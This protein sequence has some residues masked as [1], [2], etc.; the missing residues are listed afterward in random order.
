MYSHHSHSIDHI[1][2]GVDSL[3]A[4]IEEV[5]RQEFHTYCLTEHT[6]RLTPSLL[7]PEER[8][9]TEQEDLKRLE[10]QFDSYIT[11]AQEIKAVTTGTSIIIGMEVEACDL[12]HINYAIELKEKHSSVLKF[13]VGSV[14]HVNGIPI[15]FSEDLWL[16][17]LQ[18]V[19]NN[20]KKLL[21]EYFNMQYVMLKKLRPKIVGHFDLIRLFIPKTGAYVNTKSG[22]VS[23]SQSLDVDNWI[24]IS[25]ISA[26]VMSFWNDIQDLIIRNLTLI[27]EYEGLVEINSS[28]F[29]KGL[30]EP[31]PHRDVGLLVKKYAKGRFVLSDDAHAVLHVGRDYDRVLDYAEDVLKLKGLHF[32]SENRA[33]ELEINFVSLQ[34]IRTSNFWKLKYTFAGKSKL[35]DGMDSLSS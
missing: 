29:R 20:L 9:N 26:N 27:D 21:Y 2:H 30:L 23:F 3:E 13:C 18:S 17:A 6:P 28:A 31:Y 24:P 35:I 11:H 5:K 34:S 25:A 8:C 1:A 7:Y 12:R 33:G 32:L 4:I 22:E 10:R 19:G 15:D 14:H 16:E